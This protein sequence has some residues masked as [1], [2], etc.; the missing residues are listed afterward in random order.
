MSMYELYEN[1]DAWA[2]LKRESASYCEYRQS[3]RAQLCLAA[4]RNLKAASWIQDNLTWSHVDGSVYS[5]AISRDS[6]VLEAVCRC[7]HGKIGRGDE[8]GI[9]GTAWFVLTSQADFTN[10][11]VIPVPADGVVML[12]V[13]ALQEV[14]MALHVDAGQHDLGSIT[15]RC[16]SM[17]ADGRAELGAA[18]GFAVGDGQYDIKRKTVQACVVEGRVS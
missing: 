4:D 7:S 6:D 15:L 14:E 18:S 13:G 12:P 10:R 11:T 1:T 3:M 5:T 2:G 17:H 9:K 16:C 8:D